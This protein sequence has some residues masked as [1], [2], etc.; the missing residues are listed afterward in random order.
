MNP[1]E[2]LRNIKNDVPILCFDTLIDITE[3]PQKLNMRLLPK[4][5]NAYIYVC[6]LL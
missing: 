5:K 6:I 3:F 1:G 2:R 4:I